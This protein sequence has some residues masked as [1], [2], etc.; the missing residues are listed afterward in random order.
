MADFFS[1][2][3][4]PLL[5]NNDFIVDIETQYTPDIRL[6]LHSI[7]QKI[8]TQPPE[9]SLKYKIFNTLKPKIT[10]QS[11]TYGV[12]QIYNPYGDPVNRYF[13]III[14]GIILSIISIFGLG[15]LVGRKSK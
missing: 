11:Q 8:M 9:Q 7:I 10:I 3:I 6:D 1:T 2:T 12:N 13:P 14:I 4:L 15:Y 5:A